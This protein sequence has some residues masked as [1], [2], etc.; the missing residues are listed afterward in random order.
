M[1]AMKASRSTDTPEKAGITLAD[2]VAVFQQC[3]KL[4]VGV[5]PNSLEAV[6]ICKYV[7]KC[8][9]LLMSEKERQRA[10]VN[11]LSSWHYTREKP[12]LFT[13]HHAR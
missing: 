7:R 5:D 9:P 11:K 2:L 1:A 4:P 13:K 6:K 8:R 3:D 10:K 12:P